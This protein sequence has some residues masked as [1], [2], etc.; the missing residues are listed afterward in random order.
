MDAEEE[1]FKGNFVPILILVKNNQ[2]PLDWRD[3]NGF[4]LLHHATIKNDL[5]II[6]Y[7]IR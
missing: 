1:I 5:S 2:I 7:L 3:Q 6:K 4:T